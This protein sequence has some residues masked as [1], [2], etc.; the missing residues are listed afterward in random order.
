MVRFHYMASCKF[1][2]RKGLS[3]KPFVA[4]LQSQQICN[5]TL[6]HLRPISR[7][8]QHRPGLLTVEKPR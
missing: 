5:E 6:V 8:A 1:F 3:T 7:Y 2:R 4:I